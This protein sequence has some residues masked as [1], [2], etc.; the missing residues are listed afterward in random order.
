M[1]IAGLELE[2]SRFSQ[3]LKFTINHSTKEDK[4]I[5]TLMDNKVPMENPISSSSSDD[6][7]G[8]WESDS[9]LNQDPD[10]IEDWKGQPKPTTF[11][12]RRERNEEKR[13]RIAVKKRN[14]E[15]HGRCRSS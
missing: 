14:A 6:D 10:Y 12:E 11:E 3:Q 4:V 7:I 9:E 5:K 13:A 8:A 1:P 2:T 15:V